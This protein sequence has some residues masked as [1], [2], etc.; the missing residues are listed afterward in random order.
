MLRFIFLFFIS[1]SFS[2]TYNELI[3][4]CTDPLASNYDA[5][6]TVD[7][8]LCLL[9]LCLTDPSFLECV[10]PIID[11]NCVVCHQSGGAA[12]WMPLTDY[13]SILAAH[14]N[15]DVVNAIN[16]TMPEVEGIVVLMPEENISI[17]QKWFENG[18]PN[19]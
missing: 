1:L 9:D 13:N 12:S 5:S 15:F 18:A 16:S 10:K 11:N 8:G 19:N 3:T 4:G 6:A 7:D 17:I 2:C 14:N